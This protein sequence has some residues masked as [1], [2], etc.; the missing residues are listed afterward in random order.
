MKK[1]EMAFR[2]WFSR[3]NEIRS[4]VGKVPL[5]TLTAIATMSTR[6]KIMR[7][8]EMKSPTLIMDSPNRDNISYAV[9]VI[10]P[11]P[12]QT[13]KTLV[14]ELKEHTGLTERTIINC[15][16]IK[17]ITFYILSLCQNLAILV[18]LRRG[19]WK[20]FTAELMILIEIIFWSQRVN[21]M[22]QSVS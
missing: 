21:Q 11:D 3:I 1:G 10:A 13:F 18:T 7:S 8:L 17:V 5:I 22:A 12:A 20:C 6:L 14:Q 9:Q 16:T 2:K 15:Q 19:L 4:I